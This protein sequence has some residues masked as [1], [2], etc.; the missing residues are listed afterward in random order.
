MKLR[1]STTTIDQFN[2]ILTT[3]Y[4]KE[5]DVI[6]SIK[7][8]FVENRKMQLGSAFHAILEDPHTAFDR[9][10]RQYGG[11]GGFLSPDGFIFPFDV[12][13]TAYDYVDYNFPFFEIKH[14]K[15]YQVAGH[16]VTVV[17]KVDQ[18]KGNFIIEH[19]TTWSG[20]AYSRYSQS[21]QKDFYMDI[22][23]AD[24]V[25]YKVFELYDGSAGIVLKGVHPFYFDRDAGLQA[26]IAKALD[27]FIAFVETRNLL[28]YLERKEAT[29]VIN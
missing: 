5:K 14:T 17:A 28:P 12:I 1:V 22:F 3:A 25:V 11:T 2:K 21:L 20:F 9:Y 19:K 15:E 10:C 6:D 27:E 18:L 8:I 4:V 29:N 23:G 16:S 26:R 24:R 13:T 7:G